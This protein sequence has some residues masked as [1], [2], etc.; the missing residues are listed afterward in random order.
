MIKLN[1]LLFL[2]LP[3]LSISQENTSF[4]DSSYFESMRT[5]LNIKLG[6]DN[7]IESFEYETGDDLK[8]PWEFAEDFSHYLEKYI[9]SAGGLNENDKQ[10]AIINSVNAP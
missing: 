10:E 6:L 5:K 7:D 1:L 4:S 8:T 3:F 9:V 2:T